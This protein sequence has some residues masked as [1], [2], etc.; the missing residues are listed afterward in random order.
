[1][2]IAD[3]PR[4]AGPASVA[5]WEDVGRA[6]GSLNPGES[7]LP[8]GATP[9]PVLNSG[10]SLV[11]GRI[12]VLAPGAVPGYD[13]AV[14][15]PVDTLGR[16]YDL[17]TPAAVALAKANGVT[18]EGPPTPPGFRL[19]A[20]AGV[21]TFKI[22][23]G[24]AEVPWRGF[25]SYTAPDQYAINVETRLLKP[26]A[27]MEVVQWYEGTG[28]GLSLLEIMGVPVI[29]TYGTTESKVQPL[30]SVYFVLGDFQVDISAIAVPP[31]ITVEFARRWIEAH[32]S[33]YDFAGGHE[34]LHNRR[35]PASERSRD[36]V[37]LPES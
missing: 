21:E 26:G 19:E 32:R 10:E 28:F 12:Q 35:A 17:D 9:I 1:M 22:G 25:Y 34:L 4:T 2:T 5:T 37:D 27:P 20:G 14:L 7:S 23:P 3:A 29:F 11:F 16:S 15:P 6:A 31:A 18:V 30:G 13:G 33:A 8:E 24:S 36:A